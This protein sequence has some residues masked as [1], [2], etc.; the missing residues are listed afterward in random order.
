[1]NSLLY[2]QIY[3]CRFQRSLR[4]RQHQWFNPSYHPKCWDCENVAYSR[5][6]SSTPL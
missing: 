1:M 2:I 5:H 4:N 3:K 6:E